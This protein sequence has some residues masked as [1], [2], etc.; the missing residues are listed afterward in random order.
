VKEPAFHK[1]MT[2]SGCIFIFLNRSS[3]LVLAR[4]GRSWL[5]TEKEVCVLETKTQER[6]DI[7]IHPEIS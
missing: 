4:K 5:A 7:I 6:E 2:G 1:E 3:V